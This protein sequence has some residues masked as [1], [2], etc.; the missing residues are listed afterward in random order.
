MRMRFRYNRDPLCYIVIMCQV[1]EETYHQTR[2]V[3]ETRRR[4]MEELLVSM[5]ECSS[6]DVKCVLVR[7]VMHRYLV[8]W[9]DLSYKDCSWENVEDITD[10]E[11][12]KAYEKRQI[13]PQFKLEPPQSRAVRIARGEKAILQ[14]KDGKVDFIKWIHDRLSAHISGRDSG[15]YVRIIMKEKTVF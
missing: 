10:K 9:V 4:E 6:S 11:L 8:K 1:L 14:F 12:L 3:Y 13:I 2:D 5:N 15:G 7:L